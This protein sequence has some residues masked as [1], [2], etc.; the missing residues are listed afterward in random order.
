VNIPEAV[1]ALKG[2]LFSSATMTLFSSVVTRLGRTLRL[3][4]F[5]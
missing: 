1:A 2:S 3:R 4:A 5:Q